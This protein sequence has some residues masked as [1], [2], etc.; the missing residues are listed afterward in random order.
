M[1]RAVAE[2]ELGHDAADNVADVG[3]AFLEELVLDLIEEAGVFVE[4]FVQGHTQ[5]DDLTLLALRYLGT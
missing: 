2:G 1:G 4:D 5:S 3:E